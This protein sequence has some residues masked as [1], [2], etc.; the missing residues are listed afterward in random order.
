MQIDFQIDRTEFKM[1]M[2]SEIYFLVK[3][4]AGKIGGNAI[5][6]IASERLG[7]VKMAI[8]PGP[9][10]SCIMSRNHSHNYLSQHYICEILPKGYATFCIKNS[11]HIVLLI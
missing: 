7:D 8:N 1:R 4:R 9:D 5:S 6:E 3:W 10:R 2:E 11:S